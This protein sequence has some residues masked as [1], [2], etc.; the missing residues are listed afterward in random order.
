M[1]PFKHSQ[2]LFDV[3][4]ASDKAFVK[5]PQCGHDDVG[6][7]DADVFQ[8]AITAFISHHFSAPNVSPSQLTPV[9]NR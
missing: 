9:N 8:K 4:A 6:I 2:H 1:V 5:L 7:Y 3:S